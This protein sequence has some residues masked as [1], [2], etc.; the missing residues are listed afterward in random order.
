MRPRKTQRLVRARVT[1]LW[2]ESQNECRQPLSLPGM[3]VSTG[4]GS[5]NQPNAQWRVV[6]GVHQLHPGKTSMTSNL[7]RF[8][9]L[10]QNLGCWNVHERPLK[11]RVKSS[12]SRDHSSC[13]R[14][15]SETRLCKIRLRLR[16]ALV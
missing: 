3:K 4:D 8:R 9:F 16:Q 6:S 13:Q 10:R 15:V 12:E 11:I 5:G 14:Y 2:L 7:G 1:N